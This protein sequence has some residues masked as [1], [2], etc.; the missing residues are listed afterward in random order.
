MRLVTSI[1]TFIWLYY[2]SGKYVC[3]IE[4]GRAR[5]YDVGPLAEIDRIR[6]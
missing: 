2:A 3:Q 1:K 5:R 4:F 6:G